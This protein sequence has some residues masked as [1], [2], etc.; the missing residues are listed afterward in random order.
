MPERKKLFCRG[1]VSIGD[2]L[3]SFFI[4]LFVFYSLSNYWTTEFSKV[5]SF[6]T[7]TAMQLQTIKITDLLVKTK[8]YPENWDKIVQKNGPACDNEGA[9][10]VIGLAKKENALS[11]E[12]M[13]QFV[14]CITYSRS[15]DIMKLERYDYNFTLSVS[16]GQVFTKGISPNDLEKKSISI[17]R[18]VDFSGFD[19][20]LEF[21]LIEK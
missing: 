4:F 18:F 6:R 5:N 9:V 15:L 3:V 16:T 2:A 7:T 13:S 12:K 11:N 21:M 19:A 17:K 1:Q 10:E 20:N 14:N 8:G